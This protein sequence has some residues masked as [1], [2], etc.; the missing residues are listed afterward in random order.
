LQPLGG[1]EK[2]VLNLL[3]GPVGR[4]SQFDLAEFGKR[5]FQKA[6]ELLIDGLV[7]LDAS[8]ARLQIV[9]KPF[10]LFFPYRL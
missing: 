1:G 4:D 2:G 10:A 6:D 5:F 7:A 3:C 8:F 9:E